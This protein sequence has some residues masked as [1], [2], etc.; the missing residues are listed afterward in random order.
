VLFLEF[1]IGTDRF[2]V[3]TKRVVEVL[4]LV[5][6]KHVPE[7]SDGVVG[8]I[9][10][11]RTALP[12]ID[13]SL[14]VLGRPAPVRMSTRIVL[15]DTR[16]DLANAGVGDSTA[17]LCL[18]AERVT[19]TLRHDP[20][21]FAVLRGVAAIAPYLGPVLTDARGIVQRIEVEHLRPPSA[22]AAVLSGVPEAGE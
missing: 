14:L 1:H 10:Y 19:G 21:E 16:H 18:I 3:E 7:S 6:W 11:H 12:V 8:L 9:N 22:R 2:V 4:P 20:S 13:L 17:L 5:Q 15:V